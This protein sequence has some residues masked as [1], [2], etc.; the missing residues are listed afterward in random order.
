MNFLFVHQNFPGQYLHLA[1][2]LAFQP[3]HR[4]VAITQRTDVSLPGVRTIVYRPPR[5]TTPH[6]HHYL[7]ESEAGVLNAQ[8]VARVAQRI[9]QGGHAIPENV[10]HRRF[11][12]GLHNLMQHYAPAVDAWALYD[13]S[14]DKPLLQDWSET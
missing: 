12:A 5:D 6:L 3:G 10:I 14:G 13:N 4:L 2:Y 8:A 7:K 11:N 1:R 9:K